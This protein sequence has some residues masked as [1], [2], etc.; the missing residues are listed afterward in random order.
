MTYPELVD[1]LR[2]FSHAVYFGIIAAV[3]HLLLLGGRFF[4]LSGGGG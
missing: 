2:D 1:V 3:L 4:W